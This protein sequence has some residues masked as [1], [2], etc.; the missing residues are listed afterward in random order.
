MHEGL[1]VLARCDALTFAVFGRRVWPGLAPAVE[2][3]FIASSVG[4]SGIVAGRRRTREVAYQR[5]EQRLGLLQIA[6]VKPL[7]EPPV[8]RSQQFARLPHFALVAPEASKGSWRH[9]V[10]RI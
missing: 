8:D 3:L 5:V 10:P 4:L 1:P 7:G 9:G 6:C 2:R